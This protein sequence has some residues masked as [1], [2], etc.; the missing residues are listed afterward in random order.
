MPFKSTTR[1]P[2]EL[3]DAIVSVTELT[4]AFAVQSAT[5]AG[6]HDADDRSTGAGA[7][8]LAAVRP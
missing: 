8:P 5:E 2:N 1:I 6:R 7:A 3:L 4:T